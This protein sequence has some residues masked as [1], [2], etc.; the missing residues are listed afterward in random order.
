FDD[1]DQPTVTLVRLF[2]MRGTSTDNSTIADACLVSRR[3]ENLPDLQ[4]YAARGIDARRLTADKAP[5]IVTTARSHGP[6][7]GRLRSVLGISS[8][9]A[10]H[11]LH[12]TQSAKNLGTLDTLF[13]TFML[14]EPKTFERAA[15]AVEQFGELNDAHRHV[16]DLR[17]QAEVLRRAVGAAQGYE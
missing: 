4:D 6:C 15:N 2:H 1:G 14:D 5:G 10:L 16:V 12:K 7:Y 8:A 13:R 17:Q 11:L 3:G 9:N